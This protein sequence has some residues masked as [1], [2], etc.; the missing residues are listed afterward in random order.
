MDCPRLGFGWTTRVL[1]FINLGFLVLVFVF[2][3]PRLPPRTSGPI[4]DL[5]A[6]RQ[7]VYATFVIGVFFYMWALYYTFYFVS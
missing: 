5:A 3:R 2:L 7:P 4:I 1:A 6:F